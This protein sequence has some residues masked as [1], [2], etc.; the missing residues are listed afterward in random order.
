MQPHA[1]RRPHGLYPHAGRHFPQL[2]QAGEAL[3]AG[4]TLDQHG[5]HRFMVER[6][7]PAWIWIMALLE[8]RGTQLTLAGNPERRGVRGGAASSRRGVLR[9]QSLRRVTPPRG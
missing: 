3:G 7:A 5:Q 2:L 9:R 8:W 6:D 4:R 1:A